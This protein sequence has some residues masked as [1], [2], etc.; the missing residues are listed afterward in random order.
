MI[1]TNF[2]NFLNESY[3]QINE[4]L[5]STKL[6]NLITM[7]KGSKS[8]LKA[9]YGLMKIDLANIE[10]HQLQDIDPKKGKGQTGWV[11]Y[12]TTQVKENPYADT[13]KYGDA[14]IPANTILALGK[15]KDVAYVKHTYDR[16]KGYQYSLT[17]NPKGT[18]RGGSPEDIGINKKYRGWDASGIYNVK[19]VIELA[20][21]AFVI[22]PEVLPNTEDKRADRAAA[23]SGAISFKSAEEFRD[24]NQARYKEILAT[25]ANTLDIDKLVQ[26]AVEEV[27]G[28]MSDGIKNKKTNQYDEFIMGTGKDGRDFKM[29]DL[30][31]FTTNLMDDY[32]RWTRFANAAEK[33]K[34]G[35]GSTSRDTQWEVKYNEKEAKQYAKSIKDR[36]N[37]LKSKNLAW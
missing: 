26:K 37:K 35:K 32:E 29:R 34:T 18:Y 33:A 16:K 25:R 14:S 9:L 15:G 12:Y 23:K 22:N 8:I 28:I 21:G 1:H 3:F 13:D 11:V 31:N 17:L 19:R 7:K 30:T 4:A 6:R 24:A 10:D 5:K 2:K 36:L 20:D 27:A